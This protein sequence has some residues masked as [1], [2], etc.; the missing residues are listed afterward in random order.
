MKKLLLF[1][2]F[3][4]LVMA[5]VSCDGILTNPD[6]PNDPDDPDNPGVDDPALNEIIEFKDPNFLKALLTVQKMHFF[7]KLWLGDDTYVVDVDANKD[8][9]I[10]VGEARKVKALSLT[11]FGV[12]KWT[13][14]HVKEM[15]EIKY[16]TSLEYLDF[17]QSTLTSLDVSENKNL[18]VLVGLG[19]EVL[20]GI[21]VSGC[22]NLHTL[23]MEE[24]MISEID[25]SD[26][27]ELR[28]LH[29]GYYNDGSYDHEYGHITSI[30]VSKNIKLNDLSVEGQLIT[31]L[32]ISN[33]KE[34]VS[35]DCAYCQL[36]RLDVSNNQNLVSLRC[37]GNKLTELDLSANTE[38]TNLLCD[39]NM[40]SR[41]DL[42]NNPYL[43]ELQCYCNQLT[44]INVSNCRK[45]SAMTCRDNE[46]TELDLRNN[47][48]LYQLNCSNNNL[49]KIILP[50]TTKMGNYNIEDITREYGNII[51][52]VDA[53][54][55][56]LERIELSGH[57][58]YSNLSCNI[59]AEGATGVRTRLMTENEYNEE[60]EEG[61][62]DYSI[63]TS[64]DSNDEPQDV[65][66]KAAASGG[67]DWSAS[68]C[69]DGTKYIFLVMATYSNGLYRIEKTELQTAKLVE[70]ESW[71]LVSERAVFVCG[72]FPELGS[73]IRINGVKVYKHTDTDVF[74]MDDPFY[75]IEKKFP[76]LETIF[77]DRGWHT[78]R[79]GM[80]YYTLIDARN[81]GKVSVELNRPTTIVGTNTGERIY[82][83]HFWLYSKAYD[84]SRYSFGK[85][86]KKNAIIE[87]GHIVL[88][89]YGCE[90]ATE[91]ESSLIFDQ[92]DPAGTEDFGKAD[93]KYEW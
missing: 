35:L 13:E 53:P 37:V 43:E 26:C 93:G 27:P 76:E 75:D 20:T 34:L 61:L 85:Y 50:W 3:P 21:N 47:Y 40:L 5:A 36:S 84:D 51:E 68:D 22:I 7:D 90:C 87:L 81:P 23:Y 86:D 1:L 42:S 44:E 32:D 6:G 89:G 63:V 70:S 45:L 8:G 64:Y 33:N 46:L 16:F 54:A 77:S 12:D 65:V 15:P 67:Y 78:E 66:D 59:K 73:Q 69:S 71:E 56:R 9:K 62:N 60:R 17:S 18:K 4:L 28:K 24:S 31:N 57:E 48:D 38:L 82:R 58:S 39:N 72:M 25:L 55:F 52:Y 2:T 19:D 11:R 92:K 49:G 41:L 30:D 83:F 88:A 14:F 91:M 10:S 80:E 74:K 29:L 79:D